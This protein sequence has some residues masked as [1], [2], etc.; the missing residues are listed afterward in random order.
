[1]VS[2]VLSLDETWTVSD[3]ACSVSVSFYS[4]SLFSDRFSLLTFYYYCWGGGSSTRGCN[5]QP[6]MYLTVRQSTIHLSRAASWV[7]M[8][9]M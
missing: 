5:P 8:Y 1:M 2:M 9:C 6:Y 3:C 4:L 7:S